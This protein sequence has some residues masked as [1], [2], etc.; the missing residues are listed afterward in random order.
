MLS[1]QLVRMNES[2]QSVHRPGF[3]VVVVLRPLLSCHVHQRRQHIAFVVSYSLVFP[4]YQNLAKENI[5]YIFIIQKSLEK[6][7][8][9]GIMIYI[10]E[11]S[12]GGL[13]R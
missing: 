8:G 1:Y 4:I 5:I 9:T 12:G 10:P 3:E 2:Y 11:R 7:R 6:Y 13:L